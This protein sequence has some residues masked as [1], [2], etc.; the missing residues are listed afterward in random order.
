VVNRHEVLGSKAA[1]VANV[2]AAQS[3]QGHDSTRVKPSSA[4]VANNFVD[5]NSEY[6]GVGSNEWQ[7][8]QPGY[9]GFPTFSRETLSSGTQK[10]RMPGSFVRAGSELTVNSSFPGDLSP[11]LL[12]GNPYNL[13]ILHEQEHR[14]FPPVRS[15]PAYPHIPKLH[16][17][18]SHQTVYLA[19]LK[20]LRRSLPTLPA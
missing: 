12:Q 4:R 3:Q 19:I 15:S 17:T 20:L 9:L 6:G 11:T 18:M 2:E 5:V 8:A 13:T 7:R 10:P 14:P 16:Q 1:T